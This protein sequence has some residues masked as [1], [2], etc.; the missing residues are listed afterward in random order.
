MVKSKFPVIPV[1]ALILAGGIVMYFNYRSHMTPEEIM[2]E[3]KQAA[4]ST[5]RKAETGAQI[6]NALSN[7]IKTEQGGPIEA[8]HEKPV[9]LLSAG[10]IEPINPMATYKPKPSD[11]MTQSNWYSKNA[12]Q[13]YGVSSQGSETGK[14]PQLKKSGEVKN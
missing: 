10:I 11:N 6:S 9:T 14:T 2:A 12:L 4:Q 5:S 8:S 3:Q 7:S 13:N 1:T